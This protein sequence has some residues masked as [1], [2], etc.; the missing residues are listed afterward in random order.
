MLSVPT[1]TGSAV[2][3]IMKKELRI[4][5]EEKPDHLISDAN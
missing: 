4:Y 2:H 5:V 1:T 3:E